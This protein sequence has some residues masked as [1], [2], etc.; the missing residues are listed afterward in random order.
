MS[1][2]DPDMRLKRLSSVLQRAIEQTLTRG[3]SDPRIR[4]LISVTEIDLTRDLKLAKVKVSVFPEEHESLTMHGLKDATAHIRRKVMDQIH[5]REMPRLVFE[6]DNGLK[7]QAE[8]M[9][10]LAKARAEYAETDES[11][12]EGPTKDLT[13][14]DAPEGASGEGTNP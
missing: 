4:G 13:D 9:A 11:P 14:Q 5:I 3:L 12:T 2:A 6:L 1:P 8:V 7:K 10:L